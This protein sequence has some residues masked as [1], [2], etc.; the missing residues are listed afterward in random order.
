[1]TLPAEM[2][3]TWRRVPA[4][5]ERRT[6]SRALL[7]E[8]LPG[9]TF[10]SRCPRCGGDHGRVHVGGTDATVS[11]SYA[12]GWAV[13]VTAPGWRR[14]G[15]DA[16][17]ASASGFDHVLPG[18]DARSWARVEAVLKVDGRGLAVD[19]LRVRFADSVVP[20]AEWTASIDDGATLV[21]W[22]VAGPSG[23][24]LAVAAD[25]GAAHPR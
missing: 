11:V 18:G 13:V 9:A 7:G 5:V 22:D 4:G 1:M 16:V 21:G 12:E 17:P 10:A 19:P 24:I 3:V 14:V 25:P 2:S 8:L 23:V 15:L 6:V 20:G